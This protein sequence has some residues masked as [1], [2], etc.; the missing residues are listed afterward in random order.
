VN[1]Q[2]GVGDSKY[3]VSRDPRLTDHVIR[4]MRSANFTV[5]MAYRPIEITFAIYWPYN[6]PRGTKFGV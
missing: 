5:E 4:R 6:Q 2:S 1:R 3:V